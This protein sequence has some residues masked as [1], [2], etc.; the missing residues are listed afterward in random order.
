MQT[1]LIEGILKIVKEL[2]KLERCREFSIA[3]T[4]LETAA[5]WLQA[6]K[7]SGETT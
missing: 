5:L 7:G 3:I 4:H 2:N 6:K 1:V